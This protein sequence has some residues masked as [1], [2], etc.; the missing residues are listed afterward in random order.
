MPSLNWLLTSSELKNL[1]LLTG[2]KNLDAPILSVNV[3]D[4]PDVIKWFKKDELILTTGFVFKEHPELMTESIKAMKEIGCCAL[5][6]KIPRF[7]RAVP[8]E[9]LDIAK[10]HDFPLLELPFFY[11][12]SEIMQCVFHQ[13][14]M[15]E[16]ASQQKFQDIMEHLENIKQFFVLSQ[17]QN[18]ILEK[19]YENSSSGFLRILLQQ[20]NPAPAELRELCTF[21]GFPYQKA[22]ICLTFTTRELPKEHKTDTLNII[23]SLLKDTFSPDKNIVTYT[24]ENIFCCFLI[25]PTEYHPLKAL[26]EV[27][28]IADSLMERLQHITKAPLPSGYSTF[29]QGLEGIRHAFD[30]SLQ[31]ISLQS[32]VGSTGPVSYLS[33]LPLQM[34]SATEKKNRQVLIQNLLQPVLQYDQQHETSFLDTLTV[35]LEKDGN[36]S[37]AA[38]ALFLHRNTMIQRVNKIKELLQVQLDDPREIL[39]LRLALLAQDF[40]QQDA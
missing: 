3:L 9:L 33:M 12:F 10:Q 14:D 19:S 34:I 39:L 29:H 20:H 24:D 32:G 7:F 23:R 21:Y 37:A 1:K 4:N 26:K 31:A 15:E 8:Q 6:I 16:F 22:W 17:E 27:E 2:H 25:Y 40:E 5:G 35:Y 18:S 36:I 11:S 28:D 30:E 38:K 13:I